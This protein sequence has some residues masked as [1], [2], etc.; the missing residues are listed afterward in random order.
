MG[1]NSM[2]S[3]AAN[4]TTS[5]LRSVRYGKKKDDVSE[6]TDVEEKPTTPNNFRAPS[7]RK[8]NKSGYRDESKNL[9]IS[10]G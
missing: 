10:L 8:R 9:D 3:P 5:K 6:I 7:D 2:F 4:D 1:Q